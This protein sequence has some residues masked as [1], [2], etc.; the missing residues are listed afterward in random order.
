MRK[1]KIS[2]ESDDQE[3]RAGLAITWEAAT[4]EKLVTIS[5][6][7]AIAGDA[8]VPEGISD[9]VYSRDGKYLALVGER[10]SARILNANSGK[11]LN[12]SQALS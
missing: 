5:D 10:G 12:A 2:L 11:E 4:S 9:A 7:Q 8:D 6:Q 3:I 1:S